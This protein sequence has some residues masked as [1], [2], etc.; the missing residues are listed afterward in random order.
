MRKSTFNYIREILKD[1]PNID[2]YI[3]QRE[4]ELRYPYRPADVNRDIKGGRMS[5][6]L[7]Q[8]MITIDQDRRLASL[9]RNRR[10]VAD[11]LN[12]CGK[13]TKTIIE[14]LYMKR[15]QRYTIEGL[16]NDQLISCG[17]SKAFELR[18]RFFEN[19]AKDLGIDY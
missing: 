7:E 2:R 1:Y 10:V 19:V 15:Y 4:R 3:E 9:E 6:P 13:D 11:N 8:M 5:N 17:R 18:N 14:E 16:V 12:S